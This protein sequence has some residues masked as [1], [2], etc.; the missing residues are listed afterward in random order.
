MRKE[1]FEDPIDT[2]GDLVDRNIIVLEDNVR[3]ANL[4]SRILQLGI[5][6]WTT[7][8]QNM[9]YYEHDL[10][11]CGDITDANGEIGPANGMFREIF[12]R[13]SLPRY[14]FLIIQSM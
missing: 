11:C 14:I 12:N 9:K 13:K 10:C 4:K 1:E 2:V 7:V 5:T 8:A 6:N 3:Y